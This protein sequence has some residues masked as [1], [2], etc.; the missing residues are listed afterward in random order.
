MSNLVSDACIKTNQDKECKCPF[1]QASDATKPAKQTDRHLPT[2][3]R[4]A[5][6]GFFN[7][8]ALLNPPSKAV[9]FCGEIAN[10]TATAA[11]PPPTKQQPPTTTSESDD[12]TTPRAVLTSHQP[13]RDSRSSPPA[14][15]APC[16]VPATTTTTTQR[17]RPQQHLIHQPADGAWWWGLEEWIAWPRGD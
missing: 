12:A 9:R 17:R 15:R 11:P 14:P 13:H 2:T 8:R 10:G 4:K 6:G 16:V 3:S 5:G 1:W 7:K